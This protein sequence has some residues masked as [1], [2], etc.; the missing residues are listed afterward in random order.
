MA[1]QL[2]PKLLGL[3]FSA[4]C[5]ST[6]FLGLCFVL[7]SKKLKRGVP[8]PPPRKVRV[9]WLGGPRRIELCGALQPSARPRDSVDGC[10]IHF[11]PPKKLWND[12]I[13][14]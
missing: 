4:F 12:W 5:G 14:V 10:E 9:R 1:T 7:P 2:N 13:P 3:L 6:S 8:R 11:A